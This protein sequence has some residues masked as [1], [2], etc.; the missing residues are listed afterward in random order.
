MRAARVGGSGEDYL[1]LDIA[2]HA[3]LLRTSRNEMFAALTDVVAEVLAGRAFPGLV[4]REPSVVA[5]DG[6]DAI[7]QA[8]F[9]GDAGTAER[10][11]REIMT[12]V[13]DTVRVFDGF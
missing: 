4:P 5:L 10:I 12:D 2:F 3:G 9:D 6:H 7:A 1:A 11:M 13:R 8:V